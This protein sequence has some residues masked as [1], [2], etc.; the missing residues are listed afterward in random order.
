[1]AIL[2][3]RLKRRMAAG[4]VCACFF[5]LPGRAADHSDTIRAMVDASIQPLMAEHDV[6]GMA[7]AITVNGQAFFFK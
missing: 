7:V 1:M 6:P 4:L 3:A 2:P 5:P